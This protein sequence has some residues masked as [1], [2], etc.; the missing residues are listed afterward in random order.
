MSRSE[1]KMLDT[2]IVAKCRQLDILERHIETENYGYEEF[3]K[4]FEEKA[5]KTRPL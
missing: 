5:A 2:A 4:L 3:V 1:I